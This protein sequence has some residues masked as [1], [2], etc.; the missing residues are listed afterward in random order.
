MIQA[1][2]RSVRCELSNAVSDAINVDKNISGS[3]TNKRAYADFLYGWGAQV[4]LTL[5]I[6]EKSGIGTSVVGLPPSPADAVFSLGGGLNLSTQATRIE[7][8]NF[9]YKITDLY[10]PPDARCTTDGQQ[11][12]DSL[13]VNNDLKI[14][15]ILDAKITSAALGNAG[16]PNPG[17][18]KPSLGTSETPFKGE[19]NV[20][21]HQVSFQAISGG[22]F[23]PSWK[24]VLANVNPSGPFL[25]GSRDRTHDLIITFGPLDQTKGA[26][27]LIPIA[28]QTHFSSQISAGIVNSF[29]SRPFP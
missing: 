24:L 17:L 28:E 18:G 26:K 20:L 6:V 11:R 14:A 16:T 25:S 12:N 21:S 15:T 9:F 7:K 10:N 22:N 5:T 13:L 1:I 29:M 2:V 3:R 8:M 4:L 23:T 27:A 19:K